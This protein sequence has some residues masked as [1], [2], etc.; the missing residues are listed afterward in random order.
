[1][2]YLPKYIEQILYILEKNGYEAYVVGGSVRDMLLN[3]APKDYDIA[4][5]ATP[6]EVESIFHDLKKI[7]VGKEFGTIILILKEGQVEITTFRLEGAYID[8]RRP[9]WVKF[10]SKIVEDLSRRD[11]TINAMAYNH[12]TGLIDP[13]RGKED[14]K[15][16]ILR[17]VGNPEDRFSEDYLRILRAVRFS[18]QLGFIIEES[19]YKA[20]KKYSKNVS[21]IS[22]ERITD[23]FFKILLCEKPSKGIRLLEE[24]GILE[25]ILPEL[26]PAIGFDQKNPNHEMDVYEHTLCVLDNTLP[27]IQLRLAALFH[28]IGKPHTMTIDEEGIGH[29]YDHDKLSAEMSKEILTRFKCSNDLIQKV[30][31]LVK[32]HMNHHANFSEKGLKKLIRRVGEEEIFNLIKL[33]KA[34]IKCSKKDATINHIIDREKRI[35]QIIENKETY[36]LKQLEINGDDLISLGFKEGKIIGKILEYLLEKVMEEPSLNDKETLKKL[37]LKKFSNKSKN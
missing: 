32:E 31:I 21:S 15:R 10:S 22:M 28:D 30:Y 23:E 27:I 20:A 33:Q 2:F 26:V 7:N 24:L 3:K 4:T 16:G 5:D 12:R 35:M 1:M 36:D 25:I 14:L 29:F 17:T 13:F 37:A 34:D 18:T 9:S 6:E 8:G 11:F 19:T